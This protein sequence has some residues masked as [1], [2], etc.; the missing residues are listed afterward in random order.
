MQHILRLHRQHLCC[1]VVVLMFSS[2][3]SSS[4]SSVGGSIVGHV[5]IHGI[6]CFVQTLLD[7]EYVIKGEKCYYA[8]QSSS[9]SVVLLFLVVDSSLSSNKAVNDS[10]VDV[11]ERRMDP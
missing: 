4:S 2:S 8:T 3:S 7:M 10:I 1:Y 6:V 11:V 5:L 9:S